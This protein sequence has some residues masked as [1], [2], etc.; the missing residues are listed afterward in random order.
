MHRVLQLVPR[1]GV[2]A[3]ARRAPPPHTT[4]H[5]RCPQLCYRCNTTIATDAAGKTTAVVSG[6][7]E[8]HEACFVCATCRKP[9]STGEVSGAFRVNKDLYCQPC[10][11]EAQTKGG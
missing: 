9:F 2:D 7:Q 6:G 4:I 11:Q 1:Q 5:P 3:A 8:Y 10:A